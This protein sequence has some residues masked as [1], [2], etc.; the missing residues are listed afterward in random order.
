[1]MVIIL[2]LDFQHP[3]EGSRGSVE[4]LGGICGSGLR[5]ETPILWAP[6]VKS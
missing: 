5:N 1:M 2:M 3:L 4:P 6:D